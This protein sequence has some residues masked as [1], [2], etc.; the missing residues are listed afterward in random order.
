ME[1]HHVNRLYWKMM[2][3]MQRACTCVITILKYQLVYTLNIVGKRA[4][5]VVERSKWSAAGTRSRKTEFSR[6]SRSKIRARRCERDFF[7]FLVTL[8]FFAATSRL[9]TSNCKCNFRE[10][11]ARARL[12]RSAESVFFVFGKL[13]KRK[14]TQKCEEAQRSANEQHNNKKLELCGDQPG[15]VKC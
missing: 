11:T 5:R 14:Q 12:L 6:V 7:S 13:R 3:V 10:I 8:L 1:G 9:R 4:F 15:A 2:R